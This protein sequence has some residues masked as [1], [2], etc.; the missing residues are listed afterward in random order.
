[1]YGDVAIAMREGCGDQTWFSTIS[2]V[3]QSYW[4]QQSLW[5]ISSSEETAN[6]MKLQL[7][8]ERNG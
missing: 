1:M 7:Q 3:R 6:L 8:L 2:I 4:F 5:Q